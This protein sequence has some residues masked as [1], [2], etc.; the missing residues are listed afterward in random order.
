MHSSAPRAQRGQGS[1]C[2]EAF[3][4]LSDCSR[5]RSD[6]CH[7]ALRP[8]RS[9]TSCTARATRPAPR[10]YACHTLDASTRASTRAMPQHGALSSPHQHPSTR[11]APTWCE[12]QL[13]S[14]SG[15]ARGHSHRRMV[16]S[17]T[18][19]AA[20]SE[21]VRSSSAARAAGVTSTARQVREGQGGSGVSEGPAS[22]RPGASRSGS[23]ESSSAA[24]AAMVARAAPVAVGTLQPTVSSRSSV[25]SYCRRLPRSSFGW[26][27]LLTSRQ[28]KSSHT[29]ATTQ[30]PRVSSPVVSSSL[31][32]S[33]A[34]SASRSRCMAGTCIARKWCISARQDGAMKV[35]ARPSSAVAAAAENWCVQ[36]PSHIP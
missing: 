9:C 11:P 5:V 25:L 34:S 29:E 16:A 21:Q 22:G 19:W 35:H 2:C 15:G 33:S 20:S 14:S 31:S 10:S 23:D 13:R 7:T 30:H 17:S 27:L 36:R 8:P 24:R 6:L 12:V 18:I 3:G 28:R 4:R 26:Y 1:G 32:S